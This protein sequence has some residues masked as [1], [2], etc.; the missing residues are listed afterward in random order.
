MPRPSR[1]LYIT[2]LGALTMMLVTGCAT[3]MSASSTYPG[4]PATEP[5]EGIPASSLHGIH[6]IR[7]VIVIVQENRSFDSYFGTYPGADGI[8]MKHGVPTTCSRDPVTQRCLRPY[9][10]TSTIDSG[11]PHNVGN[12]QADVN[13]GRMNGFVGQAV[14][15]H[16][17][18]CDK[19]VLDPSC[20]IDV[21]HPDVM[22]YHDYHQIPNYWSY[23]RHY[24]LQDH[25]FASN[26][27]WSEPMHE[28]IVSG[29]SALCTSPTD[30]MNCQ[31]SADKT[32]QVVRRPDLLAYPWTDLTW[33]LYHHDVSWA[34]YISAGESPDCADG[35]MGCRFRPQSASTPSIWNPLP[36]FSDVRQT[37]QANHVQD[38][39]LFFKA[40]RTGRLPAV[41]WVMPNYAQSEHPPASI[42]RGQAWVTSVINAVMRSKDWRSSAIF[43]TWDDWGG[44]YDHVKPPRVDSLGYGIRVPGLVISPYA[45]HSFIDHQ[46]LTPDAYLKFIEDD[47]LGSQRIDPKTD[48]RPD[49]RPDVRENEPILGDIRAD[50]NFRQ[51]PRPPMVL[52]LHP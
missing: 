52:K 20:T 8:P 28:A 50:F 31:S 4:P 13:G 48:G 41:S 17:R 27:G 44:F 21:R 29:W 26:D 18:T 45:R 33:L 38:T 2:A 30:P 1:A 24:V 35:V 49:S 15:A 10:D 23:A 9:Y 40:A 7:H 43:L 11:G 12:E 51:R 5:P 32:G 47:F 6:K 37:H 34:Y 25:F 22:G 42:E 39:S 16:S 19:Q 14:R 3:T 46:V 36:R